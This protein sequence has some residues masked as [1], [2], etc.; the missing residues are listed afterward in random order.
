MSY[1]GLMAD[2]YRTGRPS[3][4]KVR[5]ADFVLCTVQSAADMRKVKAAKE[6]NSPSSVGARKEAE[7]ARD[8]FGC[9]QILSLFSNSHTVWS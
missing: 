8:Q 3:L 9:Q 6:F 7:P 1:F 5:P 2:V 4:S